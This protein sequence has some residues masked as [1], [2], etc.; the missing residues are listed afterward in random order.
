MVTGK[1]E[2]GFEY[3][4]DEEALDDYE[5]LEIL[6]E[7]DNGNDS[8]IPKVARLILG[9]EQLNDLKEH[10]R[11]EKGKVPATKM[12]EEITQIITGNK[13]VKN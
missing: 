3:T 11:N 2:S 13:E 5:L 6:S 12:I 9:N 1:T 4:L 7:I 10:V 8:L